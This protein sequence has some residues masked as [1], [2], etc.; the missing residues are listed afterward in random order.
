MD[1]GFRAV[2]KVGTD[3]RVRI[4][5]KSLQALKGSGLT[6][7]VH[8]GAIQSMQQSSAKA[9]EILKRHGATA[10][11]DVTGF[12]LLGHLQ[13]VAVA[14]KVGPTPF[15]PDTKKESKTPHASCSVRK[16]ALSLFRDDALKLS[17]GALSRLK[18]GKHHHSADSH[19]M[20]HAADEGSLGL[21]R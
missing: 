13:E 20:S 1:E 2:F 3:K 14:S 18:G 16:E 10:C 19:R 17:R 21:Y 9:A 7:R 6:S 12:G 4:G 8:T 15:H 5:F 11:T